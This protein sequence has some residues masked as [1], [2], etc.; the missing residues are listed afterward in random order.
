E[1]ERPLAALILQPAFNTYVER[2]RQGVETEAPGDAR[3][4]HAPYGPD[5]LLERYLA[6]LSFG[7]EPNLAEF[8]R[9]FQK[10]ARRD[11]HQ[12]QLEEGIVHWLFDLTSASGLV[13]NESEGSSELYEAAGRRSVNCVGLSK[14]IQ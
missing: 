2:M 9:Y 10:H 13:W 6:S 5:R 12:R 3:T 14:I 7:Q 4:F 8:G 11:A 1:N